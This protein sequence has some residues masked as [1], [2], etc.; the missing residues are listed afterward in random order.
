MNNTILIIISIVIL[1][2]GVLYAKSKIEKSNDGFV[3]KSDTVH[4]YY[5]RRIVWG[6]IYVD[7][8]ESAGVH[9]T[10]VVAFGTGW[11]YSTTTDD[12]GNFK[13]EVKT[14]VK[15]KIKASDGNQWSTSEELSPIPIG[16]TKVDKSES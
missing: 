15:F 6:D 4:T 7:H 14:D 9:N 10:E 8:T 5:Q 16:T 11:E 2:S 1:G 12:D 3:F 13:V